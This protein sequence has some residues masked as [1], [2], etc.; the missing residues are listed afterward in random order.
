MVYHL[1]CLAKYDPS[2]RSSGTI[3]I[4]SKF[5]ASIGDYNSLGGNLN[6]DIPRVVQVRIKEVDDV[7]SNP[8]E[9]FEL[10][11]CV[12]CAIVA[13]VLSAPHLALDFEHRGKRYYKP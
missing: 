11:F 10:P 13:Y 3:E 12:F 4:S 5:I 1:F 6:K 2:L 8:N 9:I 7:I